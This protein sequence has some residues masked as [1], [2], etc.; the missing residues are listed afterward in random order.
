MPLIPLEDLF[1][2]QKCHVIPPGNLYH[3]VLPER[4]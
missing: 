2:F 3:P 1:G 4:S